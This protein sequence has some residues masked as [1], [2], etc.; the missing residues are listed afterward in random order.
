ME[1]QNIYLLSLALLLI[2][3]VVSLSAIGISG[4]DVYVSVFA[5]CYFATSTIFRP[6]RRVF[7]FLGVALFIVFSIIVA[8]RVIAILGINLIL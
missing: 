5:I 4:L 3:S 2:I 8:L 7:D 6:R 1:N